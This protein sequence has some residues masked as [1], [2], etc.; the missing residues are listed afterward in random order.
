MLS[1]YFSSL[2]MRVLVFSKSKQAHRSLEYTSM[3]LL[4]GFSRVFSV[5]ISRFLSK[6]R[7]SRFNTASKASV[8]CLV[9]FRDFPMPKTLRISSCLKS[10]NCCAILMRVLE[11]RRNRISSVLKLDSSIIRVTLVVRSVNLCR[12]MV[13]WYRW[14][15][16]SVSALRALLMK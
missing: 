1:L 13:N 4:S 12:S 7:S 8:L 16:K 6:C 15:S 9:S 14:S 11:I 10:E 2:A 5:A 3:T